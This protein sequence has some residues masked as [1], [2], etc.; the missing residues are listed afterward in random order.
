[1]NKKILTRANTLKLKYIQLAA[2]KKEILQQ[3]KEYLA[4]LA[5]RKQSKSVQLANL[6]TLE[7]MRDLHSLRF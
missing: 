1:M 7:L 6:R 4:L 3:C 2:Q 5:T